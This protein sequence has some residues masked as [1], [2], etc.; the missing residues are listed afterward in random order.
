LMLRLPGDSS[1]SREGDSRKMETCSRTARRRSPL[2]KADSRRRPGRPPAGP[3][4]SRRRKR[5]GHRQGSSLAALAVV[6]AGRDGKRDQHRDVVDNPPRALLLAV[7]PG[8]P[9]KSMESLRPGNSKSRPDEVNPG[10]TEVATSQ[11]SDVIDY[12]RRAG[13]AEDGADRTD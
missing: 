6:G 8:L 4:P 11:M 12:L 9:K 7:G 3:G 1:T 13:L 2:F 5:R 10:A